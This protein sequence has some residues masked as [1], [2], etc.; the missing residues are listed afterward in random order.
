MCSGPLTHRYRSGPADEAT[1]AYAQIAKDAGID[2]FE[3][4]LRWY[5]CKL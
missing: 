4:S 1:R 5:I 2:L 3:L